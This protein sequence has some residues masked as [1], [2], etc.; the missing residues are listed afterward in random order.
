VLLA[1]EALGMVAVLMFLVYEDLARPAESVRGA[2]VV[3]LLAAALAALLG[4]L[5]NGLRRRRSWARGPALVLQLLALP[6]G[7]TMLTGGAPWLGL[8]VLAVALAT[9]AALVAPATRAALS[10]GPRRLND[11]AGA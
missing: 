7:Y 11:D 3:T 4:A 8:P 2:I 6:I 9:A 5:A 10:G 1:V